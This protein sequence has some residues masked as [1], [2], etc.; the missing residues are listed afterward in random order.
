VG[1]LANF[2]SSLH[3]V[4]K[5]GDDAVL[6]EVMSWPQRDLL[7]RV[8]EDLAA[9]KPVRYIILKAR[10]IGISTAI[11]AA[12]FT[13]AMAKQNFRGLVIAHESKS[14]HHLLQMTRYY[15]ESFW[16]KS[17]YPTRHFAANQLAW[18]HINSHITVA[19]AKNEKAGRSQTLQFLHCS[20]VAFWDAAE[21]LMTGLQQ[22]VSRRPGTM[23]FLESTANGIGGYF[24]KTW[25]SAIAGR[26]SYVP[27][28][29]PWWAHP[30]YTAESIGLGHMADG[31]FLPA[32]D[33]ER[34]LLAFLSRQRVVVQADYPPMDR[35]EIVSR[36]VWRREILGTECQGDLNK[37]HQEYPSTPDEAFI[38]TGTNAFDLPKLEAVYEPIQGHIGRLISEGDKVRF[39]RDATGPLEI[40]KYPSSD[41]Q[42][43]YYMIGADG[44]KAVQSVTGSYGDYACAQVLNR[45]TWEQVARWRGRM[46]QNAFG[47][48]LIKLGQFYNYAM[49]APETGL[50]GPGVAAHLVAKGYPHIYRHRSPIKM[51]GMVN[52]QYGWITNSRTKNECIGNLQSALY[53]RTILVHDVVTYEEMKNYVVLNTGFGNADGKENYDDTVMALGIA[54][55]ATK[56]E[57]LLMHNDPQYNVPR[58]YTDDY[59]SSLTPHQ[60]VEFDAISAEMGVPEASVVVGG[61][62]R[63][64][65]GPEA[66][67]LVDRD[68]D[69]FGEGQVGVDADL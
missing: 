62:E 19:T 38:A 27:L 33:E 10:Q 17:A 55:T 44:K 20:E 39:I 12:M 11:E 29:F 45:K 49:C 56:H 15:Y 48:E 9:G 4:D 21:D 25:Q 69:W 57:A 18:L 7:E 43:A 66:D 42:F 64:G 16:A 22:S 51:P 35:R 68:V 32:D 58:Y 8:E 2:I 59:E 23:I 5:V 50:G 53:D 34:E 67:W 46:D 1:K 60:A 26:N 3:I 63:V 40:F 54:L 52:N 6:G 28:F 31:T 36:L 13:M 14:S 47:E 30:Q 41:R 61:R 65:A 37:F 24:Y